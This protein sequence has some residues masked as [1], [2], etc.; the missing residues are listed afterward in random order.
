[1][2][3]ADVLITRGGPVAVP[4]DYTV[5]ANVTSIIVGVLDA[6]GRAG[7]RGIYRLTITPQSASSS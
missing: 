3:S 1:M 2:A 6:Q 7:P 5:P 4:L